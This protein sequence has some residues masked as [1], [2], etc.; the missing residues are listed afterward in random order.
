MKSKGLRTL[1]YYV[2]DLDAAKKWYSAAFETEPYFDEPFY[3]GY[4][5]GGYELGLMPKENG[6]S[7]G[8]NVLAY[9]GVE[10]AHTAY[11]EL[12]SKGA[13]AHTEPQDVGD[14][15]IVATVK[16]PWDN[17]LGIICNP[18]FKLTD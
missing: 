13:S 12:L 7:K 8:D 15:I 17:V 1:G 2:P 16:D 9:W 5:I 11:N 10:N 14:G 18:H 6:V 3:V 4:N